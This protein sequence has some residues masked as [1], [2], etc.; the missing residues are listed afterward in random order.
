MNLSWI[1]G[2]GCWK[3][4]DDYK[5]TE[6]T[7]RKQW[8]VPLGNRYAVYRK[9]VFHSFLPTMGQAKEAAENLHQMNQGG[10]A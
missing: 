10:E 9:E 1:A 5:E 7:A 8:V 6:W 4:L 3:L 2:R